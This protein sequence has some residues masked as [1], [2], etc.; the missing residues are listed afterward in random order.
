MGNSNREKD[1]VSTVIKDGQNALHILENDF[2]MDK[3]WVAMRTILDGRAL[4]CNVAKEPEVAAD[5]IRYRQLLD[6]FESICKRAVY[7]A[8]KVR[9][10]DMKAVKRK[11]ALERVNVFRR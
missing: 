6:E 4:S 5:I 9:E 10:E 1:T 7:R 8:E 3:V 11:T 2:F